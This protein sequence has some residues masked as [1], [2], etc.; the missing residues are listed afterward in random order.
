MGRAKSVHRA[1]TDFRVHRKR[2]KG[3]R[4]YV[5]KGWAIKLRQS[6][7]QKGFLAQNSAQKGKGLSMLALN[8]CKFQDISDRPPPHK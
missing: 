3:L 6:L 4:L 7:L 1:G 2:A 5:K 8:L